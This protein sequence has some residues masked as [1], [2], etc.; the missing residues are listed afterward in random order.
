MNETKIQ[1]KKL[2][3]TR[4]RTSQIELDK[5]GVIF[6]ELGGQKWSITIQNRICKSAIETPDFSLIQK[7][8]LKKNINLNKKQKERTK[9]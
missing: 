5:V 2:K 7:S 1:L 6:I 9:E 4:V 8:N 3:P